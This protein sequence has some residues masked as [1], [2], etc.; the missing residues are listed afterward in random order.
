ME[1]QQSFSRIVYEADKTIFDEGDE[2]DAA[3]IIVRGEVEI[4]KGNNTIYPRVLAVIGRGQI[5]GEMALF[6]NRPRMARVA[7]KCETEL[8]CISRDE[9]KTRL[10]TMDPVMRNMMTYMVQ[11]VR[12]MA[13]E[14]LRTKSR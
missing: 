4:S 8:I 1:D 10:K 5:F 14:F 6:D 3:Y 13:D 11:R 9:F 7:T 12:S 2:A